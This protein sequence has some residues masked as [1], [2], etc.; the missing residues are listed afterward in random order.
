MAESIEYPPGTP[1]WVDLSSPDVQASAGF[2]GE[3]FGWSSVDQGPEAG[4]Y[5]QFQLDGVNVAGLGP[6]QEGSGPPHWNVYMAVESVEDA[7]ARI[8]GAGGKTF[9]PALDVLDAGRM[10]VFADGADGA[11]FSVWQPLSHR[12]A[13]VVNQPCAFSWAELDTR[14]RDGAERFYGEV[15]GWEA[16]PIEQDGRVVYESWKLGARTIGGMLPMDESFPAEIPANWLAYFGIEDLDGAAATVERLGGRTIMPPQS[17]P[18]G[19]FAVFAD[20][21]GAVFGLVQGSYD[22]PPG[23]A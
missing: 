6:L 12:G 18:S 20:P 7:Q 9:M 15:F 21:Q 4:G 23:R 5:H 16:E 14:D 1:L 13:L 2:Y 19:R 17:V 11:V 10:A 8:E 22:P 3:L